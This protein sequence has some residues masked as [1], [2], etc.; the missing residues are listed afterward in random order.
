[1][2]GSWSVSGVEGESIQP[3]HSEAS[4]STLDA[5]DAK[6]AIA[7]KLVDIVAKIFGRPK[8]RVGAELLVQNF[9][10]Q[11]LNLFLGFLQRPII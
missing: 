7:A 2:E 5:T 11:R 4:K 8:D 10:D 1:M 6:S 3:E 9:S